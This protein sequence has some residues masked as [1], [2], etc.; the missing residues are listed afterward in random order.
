MPISEERK[1]IL[2]SW[3]E[4]NR[5]SGSSSLKEVPKKEVFILDGIIDELNILK[6]I[7]PR[8]QVGSSKEIQRSNRHQ[9]AKTSPGS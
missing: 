6:N 3:I 2:E 7:C 9:K 1:K 4:R 8:N 5:P